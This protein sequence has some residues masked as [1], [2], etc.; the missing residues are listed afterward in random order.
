MIF[1]QYIFKG[2]KYFRT[3]SQVSSF[4]SLVNLRGTGAKGCFLLV[5]GAF[6]VI[7]WQTSI[8]LAVLEK[9]EMRPFNITK[10]FIPTDFFC[11]LQLDDWFETPTLIRSYH[12][13]HARHPSLHFLIRRRCWLLVKS[14]LIRWWALAR[15]RGSKR[16]ANR[17]PKFCEKQ[18][19]DRNAP[20]FHRRT[21]VLE[22]EG[23]NLWLN[24]H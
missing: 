9:Q 7:T 15:R 5:F 11:Y 10:Q 4:H 17:F 19:Q 12:F 14:C 24:I 22:Y 6:D 16:T 20:G 1:Y 3:F 21:L 2:L 13:Y 18:K 8:K 23:L